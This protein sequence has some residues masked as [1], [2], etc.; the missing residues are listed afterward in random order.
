[1]TMDITKASEPPEVYA[2]LSAELPATTLA[3]GDSP[4]APLDLEESPQVRT[5]LRLYMILTALYVAYPALLK[6]SETA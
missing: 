3:L 6:F 5:K 2:R 4:I 1:M